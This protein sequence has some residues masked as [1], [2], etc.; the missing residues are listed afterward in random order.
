[1]DKIETVSLQEASRA[2]SI[3]SPVLKAM[4]KNGTIPIGGVGKGDRGNQERTIIIKT[5]LEQWLNGNDITSILQ[6][7]REIKG[8]LQ[9]LMHG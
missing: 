6:E 9:S 7:L 3:S 5:R 8:L 2:L 4:I 1:M